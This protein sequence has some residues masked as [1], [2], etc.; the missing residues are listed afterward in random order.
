MS[1]LRI[2]AATQPD[3]IE[4]DTTERGEI[5][6]QLQAQ[7]VRFEQWPTKVSVR[8]GAEPAT[9]I[10]AYREDIDRLMAEEGYQTVDV[11]SLAS[12]NPNKDELRKKFLFEHIHTED[13]VRFFA[14]GR[15]LFSLH[16]GDKVF[17]VLCEEGDFISV[18]AGTKHWFDMGPEPEFVAIRLFTDP[19]GWVADAT[20]SDLAEHCSRVEADGSLSV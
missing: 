20:G 7:G 15:G 9:V 1:Q 17:E 18:P 10:A 8:P 2:R 12:D 4:V 13:E 19:S 16:L 5:A 14:A 6:Q 11:V 3:V